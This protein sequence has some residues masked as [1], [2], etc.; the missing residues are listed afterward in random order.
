VQDLAPAIDVLA[1]GPQF[2]TPGDETVPDDMHEFVTGHILLH[3]ARF[4]R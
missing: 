1:F 3:Y 2:F 4:S